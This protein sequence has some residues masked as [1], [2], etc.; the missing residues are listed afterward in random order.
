M[1]TL[2]LPP[3]LRRFTEGWRIANTSRGGGASL[4][5]QQ[6]FVVGPAGRWG[7][8]LSLHRLDDDDYLEADGFLAGLDGSAN[9]ILCGPEDWRGRLWNIDPLTG[10]RSRLISLRAAPLWTRLSTRTLT[11]PARCSSRSTS[12]Q[13]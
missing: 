10:G 7:A 4:T 12:P 9:A 11:P 5:G 13:R 2:V 1:A 3:R 8:K 6:Q